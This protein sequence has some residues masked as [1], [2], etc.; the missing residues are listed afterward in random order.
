MIACICG[1][2]TDCDDDQTLVS[3]VMTR[4][5]GA[6]DSRGAVRSLLRER[7][8]DVDRMAR[9]VAEIRAEEDISLAGI[10]VAVRELAVFAD[11]LG[12]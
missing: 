10:S 12:D 5:A 9:L 4:S 3:Q 8:A 1:V 7:S 6:A 2:A 11:R